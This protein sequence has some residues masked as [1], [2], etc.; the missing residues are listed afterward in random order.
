MS[1][2]FRPSIVRMAVL[3]ALTACASS[4]PATTPTPTPTPAG[5]KVAPA[6]RATTATT[7]D[8]VAQLLRGVAPTAP[9]ARSD[10][11]TLD[12][13][14]IRSTQFNNMFDVVRSLRGNW[15]RTRTAESFGKSS[16]LQVY[17]DMQRLAGGFEEL[18][19]IA[20]RN[21]ESVR[22]FDPIQASGRWGMDHGS[23]AILL[24]TAKR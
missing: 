9:S 16:V 4:S 18:R 5:G 22:F 13:D 12:R 7:P 24:T 21:V 17:L 6:V 19:Q 15:V 8:S 2:P 11:S 3:A 23:G 20:P 1:S 14:E 10:R